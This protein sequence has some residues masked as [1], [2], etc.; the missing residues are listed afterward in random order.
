ML[1]VTPTHQAHLLLS[2]RLPLTPKLPLTR[3]LLMLKLLL[4]LLPHKPQILAIK[5]PTTVHWLSRS[6]P[7]FI[8]GSVLPTLSSAPSS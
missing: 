7:S 6:Q 2:N 3:L 5:L 1:V 8:S 4:T